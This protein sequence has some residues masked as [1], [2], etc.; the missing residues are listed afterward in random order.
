MFLMTS[1]FPEYTLTG[2]AL[3][4]GLERQGLMQVAEVDET[5]DFTAIYSLYYDEE[6]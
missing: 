4:C 3:H 2:E 5:L 1:P 6:L